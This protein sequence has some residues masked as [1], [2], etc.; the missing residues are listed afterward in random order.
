[1]RAVFILTASQG[2]PPLHVVIEFHDCVSTVSTQVLSI[3]AHTCYGSA[4]QP[5]ANQL[6]RFHTTMI[7]Y[8]SFDGVCP[9]HC[10][11]KAIID[12]ISEPYPIGYEHSPSATQPM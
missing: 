3:A 7:G 6:E 11:V 10:G 5:A 12:I 9:D 8:R 2:L 4:N 1:M